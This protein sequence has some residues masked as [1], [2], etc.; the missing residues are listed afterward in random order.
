MVT[1]ELIEVSVVPVKDI[2][3]ETLVVAERFQVVEP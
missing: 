2:D 3:D 1:I